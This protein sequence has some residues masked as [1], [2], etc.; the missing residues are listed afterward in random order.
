MLAA[1]LAVYAIV[2]YSLLVAALRSRI[3][4]NLSETVAAMV[5]N[6]RTEGAESGG[7]PA[8]AIEDSISEFVFRDY[9]VIVFDSA[10]RLVAGSAPAAESELN[11]GRF[12]DGFGDANLPTGN[13]RYY[14]QPFSFAGKD[15]RIVALHPDNEEERLETAIRNLM[16]AAFAA[17]LVIAG[18]GGYLLARKSLSPIAGMSGQAENISA[19]NLHLRISA[20]NEKDELGRLAAAFNALLDRLAAEFEKRRRFIADA[21]HELR[22]PV[23]IIRGEAE[24]ALSRNDRAAGEYRE[25][26]AVIAGASADLANIV[27]DL[28]L[29]ARADSGELRARF[30]PVDLA[31]MAAECVRSVESLAVRRNISIETDIR[32]FTTDADPHLLRR[33]LLILLD[34]AVKYNRESGKIRLIVEPGRIAVA[35]TGEPIPADQL[36]TIF[37]RFVRLDAARSRH[38]EDSGGAGLGLSIARVIA[39]LHGARLSATVNPAGENVFEIIFPH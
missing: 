38:T 18:I 31:A 22:T 17:L 4:A 13:Y 23:A 30:E 32:Q 26:L 36:E 3:D 24:I 9:R 5:N 35:N 21:S 28:F 11:A 10:G 39:G 7:E 27:E 6:L 25:S 15:F 1:V 29:L 34:N 8:A 19:E 14:S 37:E 12:P 33:L 16:A 20:A 2:A